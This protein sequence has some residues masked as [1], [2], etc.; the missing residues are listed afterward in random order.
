MFQ[1]ILGSYCTGLLPLCPIT[2]V[3]CSDWGKEFSQFHGVRFLSRERRTGRRTGMH[4][5]EIEEIVPGVRDELADLLKIH[6]REHWTAVCPYPCRSLEAL[7]A[8][9]GCA[10]ISQPFE[11]ADWLNDK[12]NFFQGLDESGLPRVQGHWGRLA[13]LRYSELAAS[14]GSRL[15]AQ[16]NRGSSGSGTIYIRSEQDFLAAGARFGDAL[17]WIAP[18][19]G[20]VSLNINAIALSRS[21]VAGYPSVQLVGLEELG[22]EPGAYAGNDFTSTAELPS[23][24]INDVLAQTERIGL[25]LASLGY[26][27]LYGMDFVVDLGSSKPYAVDLNPRWQGSTAL[28]TQGESCT[29]RLPLAVADL[30]YRLGLLSEGEVLRYTDDFVKPLRGSQMI[31]RPKTPG[32]AEVTG[33][34]PAGVYKAAPGLSYVHAGT[35]LA[36]CQKDEVLITG[37]VPERGTL[38]AHD[39]FVAR[40]CSEE[41]AL[42]MKRAE[43]RQSGRKAV[44]QLY[45][46]LALR[47]EGDSY[48]ASIQNVGMG[49]LER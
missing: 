15:V 12:A 7:A 36:D 11:L 38:V 41:A 17:V 22:C 4:D 25:W 49:P 26:R 10:C 44:E 43:I 8:E 34:V 39:A 13:G 5:Y 23:K 24:I 20:P 30:A 2:V 37:G 35:V 31:L 3:A 32:W 27:G 6:P 9:M 16:L 1:A 48:E 18:H 14:M 46:A 47:T 40:I 42:D 45:R 21:A 28:A 33:D 29:G 19:I